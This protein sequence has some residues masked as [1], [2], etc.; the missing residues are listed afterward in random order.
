M[1]KHKPIFTL[2]QLAEN[3]PH[4]LYVDGI[5]CICPKRN[6]M[7]GPDSQ[8]NMVLHDIVCSNN[9]THFRWKQKATIWLLCCDRIVHPKEITDYQVP[10]TLKKVP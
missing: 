2:R 10:V 5:H 9:C 7:A 3:G 8:G 6:P 1:P 4:Q